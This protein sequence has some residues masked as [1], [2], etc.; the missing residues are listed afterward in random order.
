MSYDEKQRRVAGVFNS[1]A[2]QYDIMNDA[3]SFGVQRLWKN[4]YVDMMGPFT[5]KKVLNDKGEVVSQE[6][7][8][9][10]DMA[11]GTGDITFRMHAK[12]KKDSGNGRKSSQRVNFFMYSFVGSDQNS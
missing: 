1:I 6:P 9:I 7:L 2:N 5:M 11:G 4:Y 8:K 12:A 3:M 10:L